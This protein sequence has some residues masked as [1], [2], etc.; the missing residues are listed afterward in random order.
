MPA[1]GGQRWKDRRILAAV[2]GATIVAFPVVCSTGAALA[3][4]RTVAAPDTVLF[5]ALWWL[6]TLGLCTLVYLAT[7]RIAR[8]MVPL[9]LLLK[10]PMVFPGRAPKRLA[11]AR[12][13]GNVRELHRRVEEAKQQG[14]ADEPIVAAERIVTLATMLSTHD[15]TTRGHA[16]RVRALTDMIAEELRLPAP[17]RDRL[18]WSSLLHDIG[19][20]TVHPEVLNKPERLDA[21]EWEVIRRHPLE[22]ARITAPIADW[23][24]P[25]AKTIAEHHERFDGAGYP[26]GL[27]G[28]QISLGGRIVAVADSF[29]VMT[30]A[31]SYKRPMSPDRARQE[32]AACAGSQFDPDIVKAFLAVSMWRLRFMAPLSWVGS[33]S[34]VAARIGAAGHAVAAGVVAG[35]GVVGL[36]AAAPLISP[37]PA[38]TVPV[39]AQ[40]ASAL[41]QAGGGPSAGAGGSG[42]T[43]T[44]GGSSSGSSNSNTTKDASKDTSTTTTKGASA[45]A[46]EAT[47]TTTAST[48]KATTTTTATTTK[49]PPPTTTTKPPPPTTTTTTTKP[50]P[51]PP[52]TPPPPP[53]TKVTA[54]GECQVLVIGPE[55]VVSWTAGPGG[56]VTSYT[57]ER[58]PAGGGPSFSTVATVSATTTT[59]DDTSVSG[60]GATYTYKVVANNS[61]GSAPSPP[62]NATTPALCL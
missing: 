35:V 24:G 15:R 13:A 55:V 56:S 44:D 59:Y 45:G 51:P 42:T 41:G 25:W 11:V 1:A 7:E 37:G 12:R 28:R 61:A 17:H 4:Q 31:R 49:P 52:P 9:A 10:M 5:F 39:P 32:L 22:G 53:P 21:T 20:L 40:A 62:V 19:K 8:T 27:S 29:D 16:E 46:D 2:L 47:T 6:A 50:P 23:L 30:S 54:Q 58:T 18:R 26:F 33:M 57:I 34:G 38:P 60:G 14:V 43:T 36:T 48:T 3:F